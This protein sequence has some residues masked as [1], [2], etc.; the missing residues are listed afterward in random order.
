[1]TSAW[2]AAGCS[3]SAPSSSSSS[4]S[5]AAQQAVLL[6]FIRQLRSCNT[7]RLSGR[8]TQ[9][10]RGFWV[11]IGRV[12]PGLTGEVSR[13]H[14]EVLKVPGGGVPA[15]ARVLQEPPLRLRDGR[16]PDAQ[17][18]TF[19]QRVLRTEAGSEPGGAARAG[20]EVR[21][22]GPGGRPGGRWRSCCRNWPT[23]TPGDRSRRRGALR[24]AQVEL[25]PS[26]GGGSSTRSPLLSEEL[27]SRKG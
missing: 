22:Y 9:N 6:T 17:L 27:L 25:S 21:R 3:S 14:H 24:R 10:L 23:E 4:S 5:P 20:S 12:G 26:G 8:S 11:R 18:L 16:R 1:M 2:S 7:T 13:N 19:S 15:A